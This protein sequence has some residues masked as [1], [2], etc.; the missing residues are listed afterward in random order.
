MASSLRESRRVPLT[1]SSKCQSLVFQSFSWIMG[2]S[3]VLV[4]VLA[5]ALTASAQTVASVVSSSCDVRLLRQAALSAMRQSVCDP[6][7]GK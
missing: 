2:M 5:S 7:F 6:A 4:L 1:R 3:C